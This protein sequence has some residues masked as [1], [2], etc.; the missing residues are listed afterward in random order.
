MKDFAILGPVFTQVAL[1]FG[2]QMLMGK[3]RL[4]AF[5]AGKVQR[6]EHAGIK[7]TWP[8]RAAVVSNAFQNQFEIPMLFFAACAFALLAG[9]ADGTMVVLAWL[10]AISRLIHAGIFVTTNY[11]PHRFIVYLFGSFV[12]MAMWIRLAFLATYGIA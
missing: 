6:G 3:A 10:F 4:E 5:K 9:A 2:L 8:E 1:T 11:I 12:V 7:P